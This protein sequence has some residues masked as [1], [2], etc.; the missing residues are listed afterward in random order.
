[1]CDSI[2]QAFPSPSWILSV[3][4]KHQ[5]YI[6][7]VLM[8]KTR[9]CSQVTSTFSLSCVCSIS[10]TSHGKE[11][12]SLSTSPLILPMSRCK[13]I[14]LLLFWSHGALDVN[15]G[16]PPSSLII[17]SEHKISDNLMFAFL[18]AALWGWQGI[19]LG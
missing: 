18:L 1:M 13:N 8:G 2:S 16:A 6:A 5:R 19:C 17:S 14:I 9:K 3:N 7:V 4:D 12:T 10:S 15:E 11:G